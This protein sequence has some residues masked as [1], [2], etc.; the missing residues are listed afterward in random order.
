MCCHPAFMLS[1]LCVRN[2]AT[3][4]GQFTKL[5]RPT[6][7]LLYK[8]MNALTL[9]CWVMLK[10]ILDILH[11]FPCLT[12]PSHYYLS[13]CWL[14]SEVLWHTHLGNFIGNA[15][16]INIKI[17]FKKFTLQLQSH[18]PDLM[19]QLGQAQTIAVKSLVASR[20]VYL[21]C[22]HKLTLIH[23]GMAWK[24]GWHISRF[25][26]SSGIS[27]CHSMQIGKH[28]QQQVYWISLFA[29]NPLF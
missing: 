18:T 15:Q 5:D 19:S 17:V 26:V 13:Q 23:F 6:G 21:H 11:R 12:A 3:T 1:C 10:C 27:R 9:C 7:L 14:I 24:W 8:T 16:D 28:H 2:E 22:L 4:G 25:I 20:A 29:N